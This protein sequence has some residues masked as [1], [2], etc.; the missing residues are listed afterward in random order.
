LVSADK[1]PDGVPASG[2]RRRRR[3]GVTGHVNLSSTTQLLV[4]EELRRHLL[5]LAREDAHVPDRPAA[6][7]LTG[8]S[9]L[10]GGADSV[11]AKVLIELGGRLEVI[12]PSADYRRAQVRPDHAPL[13]DSLLDR[14]AHVQVMPSDQASPE[15]YVAANNAMLD[16]VDSLVAVWD[17]GDSP[18][19]GTGHVVSEA[20]T[21][22]IP[23]TVIWPKGS[24]R[25]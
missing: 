7:G 12:L 19:G 6:P 9:C 15:A 10:A 20:Y 11:F 3:I 14:A 18:E 16:K 22:R 2:T 1:Q 24:R 25:T 17:G 4:A 21:R 13:F 23:V 5:A 8:V